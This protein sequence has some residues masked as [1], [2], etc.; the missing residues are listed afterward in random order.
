M[1][2]WDLV[3]VGSLPC[4]GVVRVTPWIALIHEFF[5]SSEE[6]TDH[7]T[8]MQLNNVANTFI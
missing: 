3:F 5:S 1:W 2:A 8:A 6:A 7:K 4:V